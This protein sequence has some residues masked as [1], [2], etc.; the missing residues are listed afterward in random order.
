MNTSILS[1]SQ[2]H[3]DDFPKFNPNGCTIS[4]SKLTTDNNEFNRFLPRNPL[5]NF[6]I[7]YKGNGSFPIDSESL[8]AFSF[9]TI[10]TQGTL[11][12]TIDGGYGWFI[13]SNDLQGL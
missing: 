12:I 8:P 11:I 5:Y 7:A 1:Q 3:I 4:I 10:E 13:A 9:I 2:T 6:C